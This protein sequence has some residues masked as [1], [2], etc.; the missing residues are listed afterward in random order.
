MGQHPGLDDMYRYERNEHNFKIYGDR[1]KQIFFSGII[2][3]G[4]ILFYN[5]FI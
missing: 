2:V 5:L 1:I 4:V 3:Y